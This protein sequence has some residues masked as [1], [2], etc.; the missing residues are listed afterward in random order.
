MSTPN[1]VEVAYFV[2]TFGLNGELKA[3][4]SDNVSIDISKLEVIFVK[5]KG[6]HLPYF[7]EKCT[8]KKD[9]IIISLE[10]ITS[11]EEAKK[12]CKQP[13][14]IDSQ[15][16]STPTTIVSN[17][18]ILEGYK[19]YQS[20]LALGVIDRLESYPQQVMAFITKPEGE[21]LMIPI[22]KEF[23]TKI[24]DESKEIYFDLPDGLLDL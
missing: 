17:P 20:D 6:Q 14:Y 3:V 24:D 11:P 13:I 7:I 15:A 4:L 19:A 10:D 2:K 18:N 9:E 22:N 8:L 23:I 21:E 5:E 12:L 16:K 1:Y